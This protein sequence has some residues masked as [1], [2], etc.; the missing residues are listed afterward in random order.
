MRRL[1]QVMWFVLMTM[2]GMVYPLNGLPAARSVKRECS[3]LA[4][5]GDCRPRGVSFGGEGSRRSIR[6]SLLRL[7]LRAE[8]V[9]NTEVDKVPSSTLF[10][11]V[12]AAVVAGACVNITGVVVD[13]QLLVPLLCLNAHRVTLTHLS[14]IIAAIGQAGQRR[15]ADAQPQLGGGRGR[16][17]RSS[18]SA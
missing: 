11:I 4:P 15:T 1:L 18:D 17:S 16:G 12:I 5:G 10:T 2:N 9:S 7:R 6:G 13:V 3:C 8:P 14:A